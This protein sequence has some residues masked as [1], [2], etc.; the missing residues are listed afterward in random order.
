MWSCGHPTLMENWLDVAVH[1]CNSAAGMRRVKVKIAMGLNTSL[2][3]HALA[4]NLAQKCL[5]LG[6]IFS[7]MQ[8][9]PW[10]L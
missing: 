5:C 4:Y 9:A 10:F 7:C 8:M 3:S 2:Q 6:H 1:M